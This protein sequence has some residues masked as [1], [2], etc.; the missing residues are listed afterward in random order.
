M[1]TYE[2]SGTTE[3]PRVPAPGAQSLLQEC[4]GS[5]CHRPRSAPPDGTCTNSMSVFRTCAL[6]ILGLFCMTSCHQAAPKSQAGA[7]LDG[8][9]GRESPTRAPTAEHARVI[10]SS[11]RYHLPP[12]PVPPIRVVSETELERRLSSAGAGG[13]DLQVSLG[14]SNANDLDLHLETP[15]G[16]TIYYRRKSTCGLELDIDRNAVRTTL[17]PI[18]NIRAR[19]PPRAGRYVVKVHFF[20]DRGGAPGPTEFL[21]RVR[22]RGRDRYFRGEVS[23]AKEMKIVNTFRL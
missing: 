6:L 4:T 13:G 12:P 16:A 23:R 21:V 15:C 11:A 18:E 1:N 14:W 7:P 2:S 9:A 17:R 3:V 22:V 19:Q 5:L 20:N 8:G 10:E